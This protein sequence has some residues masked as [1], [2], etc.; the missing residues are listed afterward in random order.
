MTQSPSP[1]DLIANTIRDTAKPVRVRRKRWQR[2]LS[3][4]E[5]PHACGYCQ[6][7]VD[8]DNPYSAE[9][10]YLVPTLLGG[11]D[12]TSNLVLSCP[13]CAK[14]KGHRDLIAWEKFE[15]LGDAKHRAELLEKR[16]AVLLESDNHL[17]PTYR[18]APPSLVMKALR[19][20]FRH[21]RFTVYAFMG[22][23]SSWLGWTDKNGAKDAHKL[24]T[25]LV[26]YGCEGIPHLAD[27]LTLFEVRSDRFLDAV[28]GLIEHHAIVRPV[29]LDS[30]DWAPVD[31]EDWRSYWPVLLDD[32]NSL[33]RRHAPKRGSFNKRVAPQV[34]RGPMAG[35]H[36]VAPHKPRELSMT[37]NAV[38]LR[39]ARQ[40]RAKHQAWGEYLEA[41]ARLD[42]FMENV[43]KGV[44][45]AP[46]LD[47][48]AEMRK[49][50]LDLLPVPD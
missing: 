49:E 44:V 16:E 33:R 24:A 36:T 48:F 26:R 35:L 9:L 12:L 5:G 7:P 31:P 2:E 10:N 8:L 14:S 17:T 39:K 40:A 30:Q 32:L 3:R 11:R 1:A 45:E 15:H 43:R 46:S 25:V 50:V 21:P 4:N 28:W 41:R 38:G 34:Q 20:R 47:E 29:H 6:A 13:S 27:D 22:E 42:A 19:S 37:P 23:G 18:R